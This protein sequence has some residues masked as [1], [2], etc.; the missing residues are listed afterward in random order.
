MRVSSTY[1]HRGRTYADDWH[2]DVTVPAVALADDHTPT[3][4]VVLERVVFGE[5]ISLTDL[6]ALHDELSINHGEAL[7]SVCGCRRR[8]GAQR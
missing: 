4:S 8:C 2:S 7:R 3:L 1:H 5:Q 6:D